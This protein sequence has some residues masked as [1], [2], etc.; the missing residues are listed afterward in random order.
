[1]SLTKKNL[2]NLNLSSDHSFEHNFNSDIIYKPEDYK[3][4]F[5]KAI[6]NITTVYSKGCRYYNISAS[7]DIETSSFKV[8]RNNEILKQ[9]IM[10]EW[11][12]GLNGLVMIGRT[13]NEYLFI[14]KE[15]S[16]RLDLKEDK[17]LI[18]YIHNLSY[19]FQFFRKLFKW[20]KIFALESRKPCYAIDDQGFE[21]RCSYI[22]SGYSLEKVSE[23]LQKYKVKKDVGFLDYT[24]LRHSKTPLTQ[25]EI[26]YCADDVK[27]VMAYIQEKIELEGGIQKIELT[28]TG[29]VRTYC[30]N[31]CLYENGLHNKNVGKFLKYRSLMKSLTLDC[32]EYKQLKRAFAGGFTHANANYQGDVE[33]DVASFDETS[34]YPAVCV[35]EQFPMSKSKKVDIHSYKELK[36]YLYKKCCLFDVKFINIRS[37]TIIEHYISKS[38]SKTINGVF[39]NGRVVS[40]DSLITTITEQD[41]FIIERFYEWDDIQIANF[42]YYEKGYLP[43]AIILSV[44]N[45]YKDKTELK[46]V[47][48]MEVE[49][50][51]SKEK[52]NA[53]Y[54]M[55]V[56]DPC[57]DEILYDDEWS[58][59]TP[60][61]ETSINR[62]NNSV[63]RFLFYAWGIWVT[64]YSR[65]NLFTAI[66][67]FD[68]DYIYSDTDS[69]KGKNFRK[70]LEYINS[71]NENIKKKIAICLAFHNIPYSM[72]SPKTIKGDVK[73]LGVWE[74]EGTYTRFKTLGAKRY[75]IEKD[76]A[77]NI[78][79][80][81][82]NKKYA[83]PYILKKSKNPFEFFSDGMEI[84]SNTDDLDSDIYTSDGI[85]I[86]NPTGKNTHTYIDEEMH[87]KVSD[88]LGNIDSYYEYSGIH[89]EAA[90]Y[91]GNISEEYAKYLL[92]I[93]SN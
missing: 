38:R 57:R 87:G 63:K 88:Y 6:G 54:G 45:L 3:D 15:L 16:N 48:G 68:N 53:L 18:I 1:M 17:R 67:E 72:A 70:H 73:H 5:T 84:P 52:V 36:F 42:R 51:G 28:K 25:K 50:L 35:S 21:Y 8:I 27:V 55:M 86:K 31:M 7:F 71:Y 79:V 4:F 83:V 34:A 65:R 85:L 58:D 61:L 76:G 37:K 33:E 13:W 46:D 47:E 23:H 56:T 66:Y 39:D 64:A 90:P 81:G 12:F 78:T 40:A 59:T 14:L 41:F 49:Y 60:D 44:L 2:T 10:Y 80:S 43:K 30:R 24:L 93:K 32:D 9:S 82:L 22:L 62:Y 92:S 77:I 91:K 75:M 20:K 74:Y 69:V 19:E 29:Y 26:K 11:S 89:L